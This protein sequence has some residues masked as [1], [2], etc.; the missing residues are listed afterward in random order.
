M[1]AGTSRMVSPRIHGSGHGTKC[2]RCNYDYWLFARNKIALCTAIC[3]VSKP[4]IPKLVVYMLPPRYNR[5][6]SLKPARKRTCQRSPTSIPVTKSHLPKHPNAHLPLACPCVSFHVRTGGRRGK[7]SQD[8]D[9][10]FVFAEQSVRR[11]K[12]PL[13]IVPIMAER[14]AWTVGLQPLARLRWLWCRRCQTR[15]HVNTLTQMQWV[16]AIAA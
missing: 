6:S 7:T 13:A 2:I 12:K 15:N 9:A 10:V 11:C 5:M 1:S 8:T 3:L 14:K 16:T 4:N